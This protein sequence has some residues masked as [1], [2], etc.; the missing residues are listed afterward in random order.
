MSVNAVLGGFGGLVQ[1]MLRIGEARHPGPRCPL[2]DRLSIECVDV[3]CWLSNGDLALQSVA[4]FLSVVEHRLI[5]ARAR[6]ATKELRV[7]RGH[8]SVWA[9]AYQDS[10]PGG[11]AGV[12]VVSI[13]G[14]SLLFLLFALLN[15]RSTLGW[16]G[17]LESLFHWPVEVLLICL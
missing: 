11:H 3:G 15:L 5:P 14:A 16:V 10:I 13:Q 1:W 8:T 4:S 12:G 6:S 9:P 7:R 2:P 17:L